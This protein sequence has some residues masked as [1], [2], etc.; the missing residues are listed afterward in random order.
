MIELPCEGNRSRD[1]P[2]PSGSLAP[3]PDQRAARVPRLRRPLSPLRQ[4]PGADTCGLRRAEPS[5]RPYETGRPERASR[6]ARSCSPELR[7]SSAGH[8]NPQPK[9]I[10]RPAGPTARPTR[11]PLQADESSTPLPDRPGTAP[12]TI[13]RTASD[14]PSG[15]GPSSSI[16]SPCACRPPSPPRAWPG[17]DPRS[18]GRGSREAP[19]ARRS[20]CPAWCG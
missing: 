20:P 19:A 4:L 14:R 3:P 18:G 12:T 16:R 6:P 2:R 15:P 10:N 8:L 5:A 17:A 11:S 1:A 9:P 7:N 13:R